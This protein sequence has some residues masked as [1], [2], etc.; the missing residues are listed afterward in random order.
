MNKVFRIALIASLLFTAGGCDFFQGLE[1][2][3]NKGPIVARV[4]D[5]YLYQSELEDIMPNGLSADD[6]IS[7]VQNYINVW[8]KNELMIYKA[9]FNLTEEQKQFEEQIK[10]YRNDL[11]KFAYQQ[12]YVD[13]RLDTSISDAQVKEYY[14][15]HLDNFQLKENILQLRYLSVPKDAPDVDKVSA[16]FKSSKAEDQKALLDYALSFA[17]SFSLEDTSWISFN[18]FRQ[19]LPIRTYNQ[20]DFLAQNKFVEMEAEGLV[21]FAEIK[22]YKIKD[23]PSPLIY[24]EDII[25]KTLVNKRRLDLIAELEK[26]LLSDALKKKEFETY[27]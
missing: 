8:A 3:E 24:V 19:L 1:E 23:N 6:S 11:L 5:S 25:R 22:N 12:K 10:N 9:E 7:F 17:R 16:L 13:D 26:N 27:P 18:E 21:Y 2:E 20:Q 15:A 4:Y 14:E